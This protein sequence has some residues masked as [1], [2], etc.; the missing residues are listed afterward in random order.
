[1]PYDP[2]AGA[3]STLADAQA[4]QRERLA[5]IAAEH[6]TAGIVADALITPT[7]GSPEVFAT[8]ADSVSRLQ[9]VVRLAAQ[10]LVDEAQWQSEAGTWYD[11]M[12]GTFGARLATAAAVY[13]QAC[14]DHHELL[15][16]AIGA[17]ASAAACLA[18]DLSAGWPSREVADPDA[19]LSWPNRFI[20]LADTPSSYTGAAG[21]VV[22]VAYDEL[23]PTDELEFTEPTFVWLFDTPSSYSG[24]AG[25]FVA[26]NGTADGLEFVAGGGGSAWSVN[27]QSG[28][29]YT[30]DAD[31]ASSMIVMESNNANTVLVPPESSVDFPVGTLVLVAQ[32]GEG[33]TTIAAGSGVSILSPESLKIDAQYG[34]VRLVKTGADEWM[35]DGRLELGPAPSSWSTIDEWTE[36]IN[37]TPWA[38]Y[39]HRMR[40]DR[41]RFPDASSTKVRI[42]YAAHAAGTGASATV[43]YIGVAADTGDSYDFDGSPVEVMFSGASGFAIA[44]GDSIVSDD[45]TLALDGTRDLLIAAYTATGQPG[46]F[47][48]YDN[49]ANWRAWYKAGD[50]ASTVD[51]TGYTVNAVDAVGV[52]KI[53]VK[54]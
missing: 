5:L 53:E 13:V 46:D 50:D 29:S 52:V 19:W 4:Y 12:D 11:L 16:A 20:D 22:S 6:E 51:A 39:T 2:F 32:Y 54:A 14:R 25:K 26:V 43:V 36:D 23:G 7:P 21:H 30:L 42:T 44:A 34:Q 38:G 41:S 24:Q 31:D 49:R 8:D 17:A 10:D 48:G 37:S 45:I 47:A 1:M 33:Q 9:E 18:I 35:I 40:I 27:R 15:D 28:A 3:I